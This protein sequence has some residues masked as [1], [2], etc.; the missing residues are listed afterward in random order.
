MYNGESNRVG[1][2]NYL[3]ISKIWRENCL[4]SKFFFFGGGVGG[5]VNYPKLREGKCF[6]PFSFSYC[7][8][9]VGI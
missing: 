2:F 5:I 1:V 7:W 4:V 9:K 3:L 6:S 8:K